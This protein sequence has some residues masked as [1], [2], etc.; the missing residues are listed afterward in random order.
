M[1]MNSRLKKTYFPGKLPLIIIGMALQACGS[2]DNPSPATLPAVTKT[3]ADI[4]AS[5]QNSTIPSS[6]IGLPTTNATITSAIFVRAGDQ[7]NLN[8]EYCKVLGAIHPVD[9]TAPDIKFE[10][11]LPSNWNNKSVHFG[12][13][14]DDGSIPNTTA[15]ASTAFGPME[16]PGVLPPLARGF[17][18]YGSDSGHVGDFANGEFGANDEALENYAGAHVKK[19]HD[20]AAY[21]VK[22]RYN[23][24]IKYSYFIGGS[25][26]GRQGLLAAQ[27]YPTDY[28]GVIST[29]PA[30]NLT[31]L[32]MLFGSISQAMLAPGGYI[33]PAKGALFKDSILKQCDAIDGVA[34]GLISVPEACSYDPIVLRCPG[35][36]DNGD[37]CLSDAQLRTLATIGSSVK[38][39]YELA[40]GINSVPGFNLAGPD[41]WAPIRQPLGA[42]AAGAV[43]KP[44]VLEESSFFYSFYNDMVKY[45]IARDANLNTLLFNPANPGSL[46][47]RVQAV[48]SLQDATTTDLTAF[49][50]RGGKLIMQHGTADN[51]IPYQMSVDYYKRLAARFGENDLKQF[52]KFYIVPGASHGLEGQFDAA[53]DSLTALDNWVSNGISPSNLVVSDM[54][55]KT[56]GRTRPLCEYPQL[57][58]YVGG[59]MNL[60]SSFTCAN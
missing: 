25:G 35:G 54:A 30:S 32:A 53:Y 52:M 57:P 48:S 43:K 3:A 31:G 5:L 9:K 47:A 33:S 39:N 2:S 40:N 44:F 6:A 7:G 8:G 50:N 60:S 23:S 49:K 38:M 51:F 36:T 58:R 24:P 59:D 34:D 19:V 18:T 16:Q 22:N 26:G 10:V 1:N 27:R 29:Y 56:K 46:T 55:S 11:D 12:G 4:C 20:V 14:G 42:S 37:T 13:G 21:L 15:F 17:V 45:S 28:E 41:M